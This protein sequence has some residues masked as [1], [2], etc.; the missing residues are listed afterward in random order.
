MKNNGKVYK[1]GSNLI[2]IGYSSG[3][4]SAGLTVKYEFKHR[5]ELCTEKMSE[6]LCI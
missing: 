1:N 6:N 5:Q 2:T 4:L 3:F